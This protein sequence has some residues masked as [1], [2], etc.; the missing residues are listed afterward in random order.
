MRPEIDL[1]S[2][3]RIQGYID[4]EHEPTS[5]PSG[6]P[7]AAWPTSGSLVVQG[8][9]ARYTSDGPKVLNNISFSLSSGQK[10]AVVGRCAL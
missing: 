8:L 7:P 5:T 9:N 6:T 10:C 1:V 4:I 2:V 3:E